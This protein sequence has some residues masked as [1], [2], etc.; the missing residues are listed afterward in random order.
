MNVRA[1]GA[2][3]SGGDPVRRSAPPKARVAPGRSRRA[4]SQ[5]RCIWELGSYGYVW[6]CWISLDIYGYTGYIWASSGTYPTCCTGLDIHHG[7]PYISMHIHAYPSKIFKGIHILYPKFISL[8]YPC[9]Y[10]SR[11]PYISIFHFAYPCVFK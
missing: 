6:I 9:C 10:P 7:Y 2:R 4:E 3:P 5:S 8:H 11:Y 1:R